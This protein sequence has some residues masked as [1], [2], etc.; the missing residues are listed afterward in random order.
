M[1]GAVSI[2]SDEHSGGRMVASG[3]WAVPGFIEIAP[4]QWRHRTEDE[5]QQA[6]D[7]ICRSR[8]F[9]RA[10]L[11]MI[12]AGMAATFWF[13]GGSTDGGEDDEE[14]AAPLL[15]EFGKA[16][17]WIWGET[18]RFIKQ[19]QRKIEAVALALTER[20]TLSADEVA[21][22]VQRRQRKAA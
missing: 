19:N 1:P 13:Y 22:L 8:R 7:K 5:S 2:V 14:S 20:H 17:P 9:Q 11:I 16:Y 4:D 12:Y 10:Q 15:R 21:T 6:I 18:V 3:F